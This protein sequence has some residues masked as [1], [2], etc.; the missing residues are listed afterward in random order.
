MTSEQIDV[1][2]NLKHF[3]Q[4]DSIIKE[5]S[6]LVLIKLKRLQKIPF[7]LNEASYMITGVL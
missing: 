3:N 2:N 5:T 6:V 4:T 1:K 7:S